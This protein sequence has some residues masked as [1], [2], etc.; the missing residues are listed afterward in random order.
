MI[1]NVPIPDVV[2]TEVNGRV[3]TAGISPFVQNPQY[4]HKKIKW[5]TF[6]EVS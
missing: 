5:G 2:T 3:E 4:N 1:P 6:A